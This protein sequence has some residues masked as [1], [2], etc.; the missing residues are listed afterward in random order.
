MKKLLVSMIP[1]VLAVCGPLPEVATGPGPDGYPLRA[2]LLASGNTLNF[3]VDRPAHVAVF[4]IAPNRGTSVV[5]PSAG[6]SRMD[7]LTYG[8]FQSVPVSRVRNAEQ[9]SP[10]RGG[11]AFY[12]M[13]ASERPLRV[14]QFGPAG[15]GLRPAMGAYFTSGNP[16]NSM[17]QLVSL[18]A[19]DAAYG[20]VVTD[21]YVHWPEI[22]HSSPRWGYVEVR[23]N[24]WSFYVPREQVALAY[25]ELCAPFEEHA[26]E[27]PEAEPREPREPS[28]DDPRED[29]PP[30]ETEPTRMPPTV[31]AER[32][33]SS[34]QLEDPE[35]WER[36]TRALERGSDAE[37][38]RHLA[39]L[40][41]REAF[42]PGDRRP[43]A[44]LGRPGGGPSARP[45]AP[46]PYVPGVRSR[47]RAGSDG[48]ATSSPPPPRTN[49]AP[50]TPAVSR[51]EPR[52][53]SP[54][55]SAPSAPPSRPQEPEPGSR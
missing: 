53:D 1:I 12:F 39:E 28:E 41:Q 47:P 36:L 16:Y 26:P 19:P 21:I 54:P 27:E 3:Y 8:G 10:A 13:V 17:A 15:Y 9:F 14:E 38:E 52:S 2:H 43:T 33:G 44:E 42:G 25:R 48:A 45:A 6:R 30:A 50:A 20:E 11:P 7:G 46:P 51:P 22:V 40:A 5:Y 31:V 4:M 34:T 29:D 35:G 24:S 37:I 18:V 32:L 23:C 55:P 49:P